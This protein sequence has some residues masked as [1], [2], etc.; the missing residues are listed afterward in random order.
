MMKVILSALNSKYVHTSLA[1]RYIKAYCNNEYPDA[2]IAEYSINDNL[3]FILREL[4]R[5][6]PDVLAFSCYIWNIDHVLNLCSNF[7]KIRPD[8]VIILGGPEVSFDS[9]TIMENNISID[10]IIKGEGEESFLQLLRKLTVNDYNVDEIP[11]LVHRKDKRVFSNDG[12]CTIENIN[13]LVFPYQDLEELK[14]RILYYEASRGCPFNCSYCLSSTIKGVRYLNINRVKQELD[15]FIAKEVGLVK[16]VDRTFNANK[17]FARD[18]I[19]HVFDKSNKTSFHFEITASLID[20]DFLELTRQLPKGLIQFEIGV[21]STNKETLKAINRPI[22]FESIKNK[23]TRILEEGNIHVHLDLIAGLPYEDLTSFKKS[24]NE[25]YSLK[26]DKLQLG[27]L[28]LLK[29]ASI[30][31]EADGNHYKYREQPPY[32][33]LSNK[34]MAFDDMLEL[35]DIED[36]VEKLYNSHRFNLSIRY[37]ISNSQ[38]AFDF[39]RDFSAYW[40]RQGHHSHSHNPKFLYR[41]LYEYSLTKENLNVPLVRELLK[42]DYLYTSK[43]VELPDYFESVDSKELTDR[44]YSFFNDRE[45]IEKYLSNLANLSSKQIFRLAHIEVFEYDF[46][47]I[48]EDSCEFSSLEKGSYP[49]LFNYVHNPWTAWTE[50]KNINL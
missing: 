49:I 50:C 45:N 26:P 33:V 9:K 39:Y 36:I 12:N 38:S 24:F 43:A 2:V 31:V 7:K 48:L 44:K 11:G 1:I 4:Y 18:I 8:T 28:K 20:D 6:K 34:W 35:Y 40:V 41:V 5:M 17:S 21:Q 22:S 27:F 46:I 30:R 13:T 19:E 42:F 25:V 47:R 14:G 15:Y 29:G 37:L 16:F 23:V 3:D 32:Q 10:Y